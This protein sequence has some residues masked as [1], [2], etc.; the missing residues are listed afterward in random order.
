MP[1]MQF[2]FENSKYH[3]RIIAPNV[4]LYQ[5]PFLCDPT[6]FLLIDAAFLLNR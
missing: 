2:Y 1:K 6:Q 5:R 3:N 4:E